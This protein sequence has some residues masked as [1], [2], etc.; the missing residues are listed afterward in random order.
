MGFQR[1]TEFRNRMIVASVLIWSG[2]KVLVTG[3]FGWITDIIKTT[4][5]KKG[6]EYDERYN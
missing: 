3:D 1:M 6:Q 2:L 4:Y 5:E